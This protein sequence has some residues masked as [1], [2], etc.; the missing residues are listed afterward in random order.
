M[1]YI[2]PFVCFVLSLPVCLIVSPSFVLI[3]THHDAPQQSSKAYAAHD[4]GHDGRKDAHDREGFVSPCLL[5]RLSAFVCL[6]MGV[7]LFLTT[8]VFFVLFDSDTTKFFNFL[9]VG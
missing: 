4:T 1:A 9:V 2:S 7:L 6:L 8:A 5:L 3:A